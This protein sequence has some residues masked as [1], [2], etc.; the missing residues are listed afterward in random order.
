M[1][2]RPVALVDG[3]DAW[4]RAAHDGTFLD[5]ES[6]VVELGWSAPAT[7]A[8]VVAPVEAIGV[9]FDACPPVFE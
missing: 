7:P 3:G 4:L 5:L 8:S 6:G 1:A 2:P 9:A